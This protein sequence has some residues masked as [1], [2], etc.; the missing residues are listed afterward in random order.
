V[1]ATVVRG[2]PTAHACRRQRDSSA[3]VGA[4]SISW[5]EMATHCWMCCSQ[6]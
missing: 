3:A 6:T 5:R 2:V 4:G 1:R